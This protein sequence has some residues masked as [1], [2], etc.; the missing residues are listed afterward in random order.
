[1]TDAGIFTHMPITITRRDDGE[2]DVRGLAE[3]SPLRSLVENDLV[4]DLDR[5]ERI[6]GAVGSIR[7]GVLDRF[8]RGFDLNHLVVDARGATIRATYDA[9][10]GN[11]DLPV[12]LDELV[13]ALGVLRALLVAEAAD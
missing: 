3:D 8:D 9:G 2:L 12:E 7:A 13:E 11:P 4:D 1:M 6:L 10:A 5:V